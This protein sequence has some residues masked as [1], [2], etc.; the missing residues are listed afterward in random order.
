MSTDLSIPSEKDCKKG[1]RINSLSYPYNCKEM[2]IQTQYCL[3]PL[4][5]KSY[6]IEV[7]SQKNILLMAEV[8]LTVWFPMEN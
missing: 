7:S 4:P 5:A 1:G 2:N 8:T 3:L 6:N